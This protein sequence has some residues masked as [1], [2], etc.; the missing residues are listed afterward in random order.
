MSPTSE[1]KTMAMGAA[2]VWL[3]STIFLYTPGM[4]A[5]DAPGSPA[6]NAVYCATITLTTVGYGDICPA[7]PDELGKLLLVLLSFTGL[8]FF[9]GPVMD[10]AATWSR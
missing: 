10:L 5:D 6:I 3:G 9:C 7:S 2:L 1:Y 4:I 8:G